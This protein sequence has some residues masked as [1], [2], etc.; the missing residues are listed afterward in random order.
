LRR[1]A[2]NKKNSMLQLDTDRDRQA[3][4]S[5]S[6]I[7]EAMPAIVVQVQPKPSWDEICGTN[8]TL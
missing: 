6:G 2:A 7:T 1:I 4:T 5:V 8:F 3:N